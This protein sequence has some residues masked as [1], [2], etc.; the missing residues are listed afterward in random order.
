MNY[1]DLLEVLNKENIKYKDYVTNPAGIKSLED[2]KFHVG[3][4]FGITTCI[5]KLIEMKKDNRD[6]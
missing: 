4:I 2:Y 3:V 5:N 1:H 6:D